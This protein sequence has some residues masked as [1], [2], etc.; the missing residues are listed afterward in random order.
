MKL[1]E[2]IN[3]ETFLSKY[4]DYEIVGDSYTTVRKNDKSQLVFD[5]Q[6]PNP[7][8]VWDL[9]DGDSHYYYW[10][11]GLGKVKE[12]YIWRDESA[13]PN[14]R[15]V[16]NVYLTK[17]EAE[18]EVERRKVE[19]LLL[20]HGGRRW[21]K[22]DLLNYYLVLSENSENL[23]VDWL[24]HGPSQGLIYFD[25]KE[26]AQKAIEQIGEERIRKALFEVR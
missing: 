5:I 20:K 23:A 3:N 8:T 18:K 12:E 21:F 10:I 1:K 13:D 11:D 2:L 6:K 26:Q 25:L 9:K 19:T 15:D 22:D 14:A 17:E 4:G 16:G 24:K 7:K